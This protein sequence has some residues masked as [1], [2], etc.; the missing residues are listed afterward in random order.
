MHDAEKCC[1][2]LGEQN[3]MG[4]KSSMRDNEKIIRYGEQEMWEAAA[5]LSYGILHKIYPHILK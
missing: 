3:N 1:W 2:G 4:F 5:A